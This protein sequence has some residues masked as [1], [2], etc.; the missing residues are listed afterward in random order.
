VPGLQGFCHG[1]VP[2]LICSM[3][4]EGDV[5]NKGVERAW[6]RRKIEVELLAN[7]IDFSPLSCSEPVVLIVG[8]WHAFKHS[9]Q[10]KKAS[11]LRDGVAPHPGTL[12]RNHVAMQW[13]L[14]SF[15]CPLPSPARAFAPKRAN[16]SAISK[17]R[18]WLA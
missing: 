4:R 13:L 5:L 6:G 3:S 15:R 12:Q 2:F 16:P 14:T 10:E 9:Q 8:G 11:L 1:A 7:L 18:P 17:R